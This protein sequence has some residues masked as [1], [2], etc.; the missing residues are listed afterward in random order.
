MTK[1]LIKE[2][3]LLQSVT[4]ATLASYAIVTGAVALVCIGAVTYLNYGTEKRVQDLGDKAGKSATIQGDASLG[5]EVAKSTA[6]MGGVELPFQF[7]IPLF[8]L[9]PL[10]KK[11]K[12]KD[13]GREVADNSCPGGKCGPGESTCFVAGTL[14]LTPSGYRKIEDIRVGDEVLSVA[15][16][17]PW[18]TAA[19]EEEPHE[20]VSES[21]AGADEP[22]AEIRDAAG[23]PANDPEP[24][25]AAALSP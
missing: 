6:V 18:A 8:T 25:S 15:E 1:R 21:A 20:Q 14:V 23:V 16:D 4:G 24:D 3:N 22:E 17:S 11:D 5:G 19:V 10:K 12:D 13:K 9:P 2:R 7:G